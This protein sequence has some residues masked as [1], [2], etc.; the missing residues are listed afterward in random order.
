MTVVRHRF[1]A[2]GSP[3]PRLCRTL[4]RKRERESRLRAS[5]PIVG[6]ICPQ[7]YPRPSNP[8]YNAPHLHAWKRGRDER[9]GGERSGGGG[10][11]P[12]RA[13]CRMAWRPKRAPLP[14]RSCPESNL[15]SRARAQSDASGAGAMVRPKILVGRRGE[16]LT[17]TCGLTAPG[18][19]PRRPASIASA[20]GPHETRGLATGRFRAPTC[21]SPTADCRPRH[22]GIA[23]MA[24]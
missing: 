9:F 23:L 21:Y 4:P 15:L 1:S 22:S 13:T 2:S 7:T 8:A 16:S 11:V 12:F 18:P 19:S 14:A 6:T 10:V 17:H 20:G 3:H 24:F 5:A